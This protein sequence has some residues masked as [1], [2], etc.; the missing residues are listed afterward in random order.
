MAIHPD[1]GRSVGWTSEGGLAVKMINKTGA[2]SVKGTLVRPSS[3]TA[4]AVTI[5]DP[6][7]ADPIGAIYDS[8]VAEGS[9]V[10]VVVSGVAEI[11]IDDGT[12]ATL[13]GWASVSSTTAG[14]VSVGIAPPTTPGSWEDVQTHMREV[15]H[16]IE[17][18]SAGTNVV[19]KFIIH[20]N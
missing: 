19:A 6:N 17:A 5:I 1:T 11:L 9:D 13:R 20:F 15:G 7:H 8:G 18:K 12:A 3:T 16:G 2:A 4:G 10:W 14:R